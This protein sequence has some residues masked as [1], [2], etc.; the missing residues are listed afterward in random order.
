MHELR[1]VMA[2][3]CT[4][5]TPTAHADVFREG[6]EH[7]ILVHIVYDDVEDRN[8]SVIVGLSPAPGGIQYYFAVIEVEGEEETER[9]WDGIRTAP[10]IPKHDRAHVLRCILEATMGLV[11][12]VKPECFLMATHGARLPARA[13]DKYHR[14]NQVFISCGY[15]VTPLDPYWG[16][17][18][19]WMEQCERA[20]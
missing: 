13:L 20:A 7:S 18:S 4:C 19:W 11:Q 6:D 16:R 9:Y 1:C 15:T 10:F 2:F 8:Y 5:R 14:L 17:E 12:F 3:V